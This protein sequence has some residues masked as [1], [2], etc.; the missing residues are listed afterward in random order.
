[1]LGLIAAL[2]CAAGLAACSPPEL[3]RAVAPGLEAP[4]LVLRG[5]ALEGWTGAV[6]DLSVEASQATVDL[7]GRVAR[8]E[9]VRISLAGGE[10]GPLQVRSPSG[11]FDL[12]RDVLWL[13]GGV[14]GQTHPGERFSTAE[15]RFDQESGRLH[16][17]HPVRIERANLDLTAS[18]MDLD[19][20]ARRLSLHGAV[21]AGLR[22]E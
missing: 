11:E 6:R 14:E 18:A 9:Q 3:E 10:T 20:G 17:A 12:A 1:V 4:P 22:P 5:I 13:R 7:E 19:L 15:L 8:L 2:A 21:R 16:S